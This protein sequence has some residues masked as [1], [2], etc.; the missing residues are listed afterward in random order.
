MLR[1]FI[2]PT[3][4]R[5]RGQFYEARLGTADGPVIVERSRDPEHAVGRYL[6]E[7]GL[8]GCL[9][10]CSADRT[11]PRMIIKC[12]ETAAWKTAR[13][14][15]RDGLKP[16]KYRPMG[17]QEPNERRGPDMPVESAND[18]GDGEAEVA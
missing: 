8:N 18:N 13:D 15:N 16:A 9:E 3:N 2:K 1:I 7:Q 10:V 5:Q 17:A 11:T 4:R 14:E 6:T 12:I